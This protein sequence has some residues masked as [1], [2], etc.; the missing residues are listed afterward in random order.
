VSTTVEDL[1][2]APYGWQDVRELCPG[3]THRK[4]NY[5]CMCGL[6]GPEQQGLG[7]GSRRRFTAEDIVV[8]R[9]I[10]RVSV[11]LSTVDRRGGGSADL[12]AEVAA[13]VRAGAREVRVRL[14]DHVTLTVNV[15]DLHDG[16]GS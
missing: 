16:G 6:F 5:W 4:L 9:A 10:D 1:N 14:G 2:G 7:S 15:S 13:Q 3:L 12:Y 11:A 8:L